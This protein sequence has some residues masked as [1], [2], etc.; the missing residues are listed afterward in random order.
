MEKIDYWTPGLKL[1]VSITNTRSR[2]IDSVT[3]TTCQIVTSWEEAIDAAKKFLQSHR[4]HADS[5]TIYTKPRLCRK[6]IEHATQPMVFD[7]VEHQAECLCI[8]QG[9]PCGV[10]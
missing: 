2:A 1:F 5:I 3:S 8:L 6:C 7:I 9:T 4:N 10:H